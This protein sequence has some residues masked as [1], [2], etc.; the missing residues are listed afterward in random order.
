MLPDHELLTLCVWYE[1]E[2]MLLYFMSDE[3]MLGQL[4]GSMFSIKL[5]IIG[6]F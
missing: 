3:I 1:I 2:I 6:R 4:A 5:S